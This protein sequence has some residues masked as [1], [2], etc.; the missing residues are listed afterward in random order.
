MRCS[1][2]IPCHNGVELTR[3]CIASLLEQETP[4]LE[5]LIVD[6][7]SS[8]GTADLG[9]LAPTV[10]VI[11]LTSNRGFAG[12]VNQGLLNAC[13]DTILIVNN[14][15]LAATNLL[16]AL[17]DVLDTDSN[18]GAC[19][20]VSNHVKGDAHLMIGE[21]GQ[22]TK[23]RKALADELQATAPLLQ[24]A[25]TLAG[26]C[27]LIR[28]ST[29]HKIG[30]FDERFGHGNYE[31][32]DFCLRL[33]LHGYRLVIARRAFLHHEGHATF[34]LLGLDLKEQ[35]AKRLEQFRDKWLDHPAGRATVAGIHGNYALAAQA[36]EQAQR[37][38]PLWP[39]A[40]WHIGRH[41]ERN[42]SAQQAITHLR[43]FLQLCPEHVEARLALATALIRAGRYAE[44]QQII[45]STVRRHRLTPKQE[46]Q[47][48]QRLGQ[49][50]YGEGQYPQAA[51]HMRTALEIQPGSGELNNWIGLCELACE[52][53]AAAA[54]AFEAA[55]EAG[56]ALA[57]T[58]LGIC[59]MQMGN[60]DVAMQHFEKAITE[61]PDD[62]V[63][64][65]NYESGV[66][67]QQSTTIATS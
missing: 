21:F 28:K 25:D 14:D 51:L 13:G 26:L 8:D 22:D 66:A 56:C 35:I 31:D 27:L 58:N 52:D 61:L 44:G 57:Y 29:L 33:R 67:A 55:C 65:A 32:D 64:R 7:A 60:L 3:A 40:D 54:V 38:A 15:T 4:P 16:D 49:L 45:D 17:H 18:I 53:L 34:K 5:I 37:H 2:V 62:P 20:P 19:A 1:V 30:L 50:A 36:A 11:R 10:R 63:A 47:M 23:N 41:H 59:H 6:N 24:D 48:L 9:E 42:G 46:S 12:G 39:D 43:A